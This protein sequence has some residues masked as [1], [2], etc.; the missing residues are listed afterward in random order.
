MATVRQGINEFL[1]RL[2]NDPDLFA[3]Y[4]K[5]RD[6]VMEREGVLPVDRDVILS[7][8]L[9]EIRA[10]LRSGS[11]DSEETPTIME[12]DEPPTIMKP[13][14]EPPTIMKPED[15]PP[16]IMKPEDEPPTIMKP[17]DEPPTIMKPE[18]EPPTIMEPEEPKPKP[19]SEL[20]AD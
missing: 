6:G 12:P 16:T 14:E 2:G 9:R 13:E 10:R 1:V 11:S 17:E 3:E 15:E 4:M 20:E 19:A 7:G 5:D 18:E 8:D